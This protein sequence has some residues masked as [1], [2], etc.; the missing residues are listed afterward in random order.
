MDDNNISFGVPLGLEP[1]EIPNMSSKEALSDSMDDATLHSEAETVDNELC[2]VTD[3]AG[4]FMRAMFILGIIVSLDDNFW[5]TFISSN[6]LDPVP[7][8]LRR[9]QYPE[10]VGRN[11]FEFI[12]DIKVQSFFRHIIYMLIT[13]MQK[14]FVYHWFC[15]SPACERKMSMT[16]SKLSNSST[17][18]WILWRSQVISEKTLAVPQSYLDSP[19]LPVCPPD[20]ASNKPVRTVCSY[21]KRI[22]VPWMDVRNPEQVLNVITK[23]QSPL[24]DEEFLKDGKLIPIVGLRGKLGQQYSSSG[25]VT[26]LWLTAP[27]YYGAFLTDDIVINHGVCELCYEEIAMLFMPVGSFKDAK[28]VLESH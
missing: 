12:G 17:F 16:V 8:H 2:Y 23:I 15:D 6:S 20:I 5:N 21:C 28:R 4:T 18:K 10:I 24:Y 27:Q 11:L 3:D 7:K 13:N 25:Q 22:L 26:H 9:C 14:K 1:L 19:A